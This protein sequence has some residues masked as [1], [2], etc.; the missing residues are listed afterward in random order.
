MTR[1]ARLTYGIAVIVAI[2]TFMVYLPALHNGFVNWDDDDYV[3]RN[4]FIHPMDTTFLRWAFFDFH[5][6]NW[7]PLTWISHALDYAVWGLTPFGHHLTNNILHAVNTLLVVLLVVRLLTIAQ[8]GASDKPPLPLLNQGREPQTGYSP[9]IL[10]GVAEGQGGRFL[11]EPGTLIAAATTGLLFGLHPLHVESVAWV[12]ERKDLLCA[13]FYLLSI[14]MYLKYAADA[15]QGAQSNG[16]GIKSPFALAPGSLLSALFFFVL[17]LMSKPMAVS[18]PLVL[19]I[20]DWYPL[21]RLR[22]VKGSRK[23][24]TEKIPFFALSL[25]VSFIATL[26]QSSGKAIISLS[27]IPLPARITMSSG[28]LMAYLW[29]MILPVNL[30]PFYPYPGDISLMQAQ[31]LIPVL[32]TLLISVICM[33][34]SQRSR[35]WL[36]VWGYYLLTSLPVLGIVQIGYQSMADRYTYL[37]SLGPFLLVS[38]AVAWLSRKLS[39]TMSKSAGAAAALAI[40]GLLSYATSLQIGIWKDSFTLW[41][42]EIRKRPEGV[43]VAYYHRGNA[44]C[45]AKEYDRAIADYTTA[46]SL[47]PDYFEAYT[48]RATV[49]SGKGLY[50]SAIGD[51]TRA[52]SLD[53]NFKIYVNRGHVYMSKGLWNDAEEDFRKAIGLNP[54]YEEG[55]N[56][57]GMIYYLNAQYEKAYNNFSIA[58][59]LNPRNASSFV[60]RGYAYL[61][62]TENVLARADFQE[63]CRLGNQSGCE[64]AGRLSAF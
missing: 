4:T 25:F 59:E 19:L 5:A 1:A 21:G 27:S 44:Y 9:P 22:S 30:L 49:Y 36:S 34:V 13:L 20:L 37:P 23:V 6:A 57:L 60:N 41:N 40:I 48:N 26:S 56:G 58:I 55:Y 33:V 28:S 61:R 38:L 43:P 45:D 47:K 35:I 31:Y 18:L 29:K 17:A 24:I 64:A 51:Y 14:M 46:I 62:K 16:H 39:H 63:A 2:V 15:S 11:S 8:N 7:H 54:K 52:L 12:S 32:I 53:A 10:G 42:Y 50:D 3:Y